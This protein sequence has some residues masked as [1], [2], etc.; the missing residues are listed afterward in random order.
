MN[1]PPGVRLE[2]P[3]L[4][5]SK[6]FQADDPE[7]H[8]ACEHVI[9]ALKN[10]L[11]PHEV[12]EAIFTS[13]NGAIQRSLVS[14]AS[15]LDASILTTF[16]NQLSLV[17]AILRRTF[18]EDGTLSSSYEDTAMK[19]KDALNM[20]YKMAQMMTRDLPKVYNMERIQRMEQAL[21]EI[22]SKKLTREQQDEFI[23]EMDKTMAKT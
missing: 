23:A 12:Q 10:D 3:S 9:T 4:A 1:H 21:L 11:V 18:N 15:G 8:L 22:M 6:G 16:K 19:P 13:M 7:L 17:D 20:S 2:R 5:P 14:Q